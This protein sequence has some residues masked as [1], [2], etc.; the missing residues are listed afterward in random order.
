MLLQAYALDLNISLDEGN[1]LTITAL[2]HF[3]ITPFDE[4]SSP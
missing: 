3:L 4:G 1:R 2:H